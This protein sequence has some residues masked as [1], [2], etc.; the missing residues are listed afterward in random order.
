MCGY[1]PAMSQ[2]HCDAIFPHDAA[3]HPSDPA[4]IPV[5]TLRVNLKY[6]LHADTA[7]LPNSYTDD[8]DAA[9]ARDGDPL[10]R[11]E[12]LLREAKRGEQKRRQCVR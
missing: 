12:R 6:W 3:S 4:G 1:A 2:R 11:V 10:L 8:H 5:S 7:T 9:Q